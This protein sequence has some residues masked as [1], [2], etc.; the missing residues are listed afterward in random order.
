M[1]NNFAMDMLTAVGIFKIAEGNG[2]GKAMAIAAI[3]AGHRNDIREM[4]ELY[5]E[6]LRLEYGREAIYIMAEAGFAVVEKYLK[7]LTEE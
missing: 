1:K 3:A 4:T 5:N 2:P 6:A 7:L